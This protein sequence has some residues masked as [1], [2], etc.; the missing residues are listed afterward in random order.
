MRLKILIFIAPV[1]MGLSL[2][3]HA[4]KWQTIARQ[5]GERIEIDKTRIARVGDGQ[6]LAWSRLVLDQ[7]LKVD[8]KPYTVL[9]ALNR[10]D[11]TAR[12]FTTVK[13]VYLQAGTPVK[14]ETV[15]SWRSMLAERRSVDEDLL[16]RSM[17]AAHGRRNETCC[18]ACASGGR[19]QKPASSIRWRWRI[20]GGAASRK[21]HAG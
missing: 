21:N 1:L 2:S 20:G 9:E 5:A 6:T 19:Q 17:Q 18:R 10:Y 11:C 16:T 15:S 7:E 8:G 12:R 14:E 3:V 13:R 4:A